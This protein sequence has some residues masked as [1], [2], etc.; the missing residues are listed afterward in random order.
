MWRETYL[1]ASVRVN[2][3]EE[4]ERVVLCH[5]SH[6]A[7]TVQVRHCLGMQ[8]TMQAHSA[9]ADCGGRDVIDLSCSANRPSLIY[10]AA[11]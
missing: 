6:V 11:L 2:R 4:E 3:K 10:M 9:P 5:N 8:P 7:T 1:R